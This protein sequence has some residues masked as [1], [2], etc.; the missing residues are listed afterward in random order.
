MTSLPMTRLQVAHPEPERG[1]RSPTQDVLIVVAATALMGWVCTSFEVS[2][3]IFA[4]TRNWEF[5]QL[6]EI[7]AVLLVMALCLMW[8]AWRRY[9]EASVELDRRR[10]TEAKLTGLL[11][12]NR[13]LAQQH[14]Q[15]QESERKR[16]AR[17]LHDEAGQYLNAIKTDAV[18]I[19][20]RTA[21][22]S[23]PIRRASAAIIEHTDRVYDVVRDLIRQLRPVGLDELGLKAALEH[24][25]GHWQQRL[26]Q[27]RFAVAL[28]GDLDSLGEPL[29]LAI[30]R[31][32]QEGL[33]NAAKHAHAARVE[34]RVSCKDPAPGET[35]EVIFRMADDGRGADLTARRSGLG[36]IGMRERVEMLGGDL[37][38]RSEVCGGFEI[39]ARIPV[40]NPVSIAQP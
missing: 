3:R 15:M 22:E 12:D 34:I 10:A 20:A 18:S 16:L 17:E 24:Y 31:L 14:I 29:S 32:T 36:L 21:D 2:E 27:I 23:E 37:K 4:A 25:L 30:Y 9:R 39:L 1:R 38:L 33:T 11:H 28:D 13:R 19:Y 26:P 6:D 7:P 8:F 35:S 40:G 5:L